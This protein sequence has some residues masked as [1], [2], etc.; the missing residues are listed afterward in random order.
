MLPTL[1][2]YAHLVGIPILDQMPF[3]GLESIP[4]SREIADMLHIDEDLIRANLTTK[5]G[6]QGFPSEFL[7]AQAT[8][9]GR[10]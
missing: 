5:G 8:F 9:M 10:P 7:I 6:I 3:S 1:E 4:T 2:E